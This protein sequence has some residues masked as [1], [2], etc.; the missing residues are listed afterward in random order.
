MLKQSQTARIAAFS[1]S[2]DQYFVICCAALERNKQDNRQY[3]TDWRLQRV[4][5]PCQY[6]LLYSKTCRKP[7]KV[8]SDAADRKH[9]ANIAPCANELDA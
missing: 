6:N 3:H 9:A 7:Q 1:S 4:L 5:Q 2:V 8:L